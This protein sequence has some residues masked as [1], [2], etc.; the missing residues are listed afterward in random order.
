[1]NRVL[2]TYT[3]T[4]ELYQYSNVK[5]GQFTLFLMFTIEPFFILSA[6]SFKV[7]YMAG[8]LEIKA[9]KPA[10]NRTQT[11]EN[12]FSSA[13]LFIIMSFD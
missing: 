13:I 7:L 10:Q 4:D 3:L 5:L 6:N 2:L 12:T 1:M 11:H 9:Q 8:C